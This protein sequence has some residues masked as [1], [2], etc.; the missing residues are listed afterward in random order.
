MNVL[1]DLRNGSETGTGCGGGCGPELPMAGGLS[2]S[3]QIA[4]EGPC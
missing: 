3:Q 4:E 2:P 1:K